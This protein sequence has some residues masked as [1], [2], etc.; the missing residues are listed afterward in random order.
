MDDSMDAPHMTAQT[1]AIKPFVDTV[2]FSTDQCLSADQHMR[3]AAHLEMRFPD[4]RVIVVDGGAKLSLLSDNEQ[5][6]RIEAKLDTLIS[7]LAEDDGEDEASALTLDG[8][9][10][11]GERDQSRSL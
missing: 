1:L 2:V 4:N 10:A 8:Q 11:G 3:L 7:A 5:L 6:T 9:P